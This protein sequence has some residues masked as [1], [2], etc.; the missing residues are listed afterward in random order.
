MRSEPGEAGPT[1]GADPAG[2]WIQEWRRLIPPPG[3]WWR[4]SAF[5]LARAR[6]TNRLRPWRWLTDPVATFRIWLAPGLSP[7]ERARWNRRVAA[8]AA[9]DPLLSALD[10]H[11]RRA[12][13]CF[14]D[15][16]LVTAGAGSGKTRTMVARAGYAVRR[17]GT[18]PEAVAFITFTNKATEEIRHRTRQRLPGLQVGTIHQLARRVLKLVD[19]R[20]VQLSPMAEDDD[21]RRRRIAGW[22]REEIERDPGLAADVALRRNARS[23]AVKAGEPVERHRIPPDGREVKS[24]GEVV[25]G[26][27]LHAAGVPFLYEASFP[28]PA[29]EAGAAA[30]LRGYRPDFYLPDDPEAPVTAEGGVWLEHYAHDRSGRA[31]AEFAGYEE[32]RAWKRRLHES[33]A[34]RYV[35]TSFGDMQRAWDGD[36]PG[37][38]EVLVERLRAAGGAIDDP[39]RWT[40]AAVDDVNDGPDAGASPLTLEV[41]AWIGAVRRRPAGR[42]SPATARPDVGA[43]RRIGRAVR[44]RYEQELADTGTTDHDGTILE[45]TDAARRRPDL[46]PW[47]HVIVDEYQDVNPAQAAFVHALTTPKGPGPGGE[48]ATLIGVGDDW[49]AI[50]GFQGGDV[51]LIRTTADPAGVVRTACEPITLVNGYR[52]GQGLADASRAVVTMD[53]KARDRRVR[54]LGPEPVG[55]VPPVSV[56]AARPTPALAA[57]LG[58]TATPTKAA[59]LAAFTYWIPEHETE[60]GEETA[61]PVTVLV[62]G[63]RNID[64]SDPLPAARGGAGLDRRRL[65]AAARRYGLEVEYRTIHAAKGAEAD[66]AVLLDSGVAE[67]GDHA[68]PARARPR[69]RGRDRRRPRRR[70][71]ALV[72]S[73][74]ARPLRGA[75]RGGRP[76]RPHLAG[77]P[78]DHRERGPTAH[79]RLGPARGLARAGPGVGAVPVLQPR[80]RR[81]GAPAGDERPGPGISRGARTG[82]AAWA[83]TTRSPPAAPAAPACSSRPPVGSSSAPTRRA[84]RS[85]RAAAAGPPDLWL[86]GVRSARRSVSGAAGGTARRRLR[87]HAAHRLNPGPTAGRRPSRRR[88]TGRRL[89]PGQ[90]QAPPSSREPKSQDLI[91]H[92]SPHGRTRA[93]CRAAAM[94]TA[95]AERA[96]GDRGGCCRP[97]PPSAPSAVR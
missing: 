1:A 80:R 11:Q 33:L 6:R 49:Q 65:N 5:D 69:H 15:R 95:V 47:R 63:R 43:L 20:T 53:P 26:T 46:L 24:H 56:A 28:L 59:V 34:T 16:A 40:I 14:E 52:F 19:G 90:V 77:D 41:D 51:S 21:L 4:K 61:E 58:P 67:L 94:S 27:L 22:I 8:A 60:T 10:P 75:H 29:G 32:A 70:A 85:S 36:G 97:P 81:L 17:L 86:Y 78:S 37:M 73:A 74:D 55:G 2:A 23:A 30:D 31:P 25:I 71:P 91:Q 92:S 54:D 89:S 84:A 68:G 18:P 79:A 93:R 42:P 38:A 64:V 87:P 62:M 66:Y 9:A 83:A 3:V 13:A 45:A 39:E 48:G 50:F 12:A 82:T 35:E 72:R 76:R 57:E 44:R 88:A 96:R 7:A